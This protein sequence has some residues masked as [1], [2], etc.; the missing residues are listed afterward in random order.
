MNEI[1]DP[2]EVY[3]GCYGRVSVTLYPYNTNGSKG[4]AYGLQNVQKLTDGDRLG[5][6][7]SAA[8]DFA[9]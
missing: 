5:G 8:A 7:S 4:I 3:S 6:S 9:I 2:N 1:I